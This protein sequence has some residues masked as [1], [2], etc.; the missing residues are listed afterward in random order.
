MVYYTE[1]ADAWLRSGN[2]EKALVVYK[3]AARLDSTSNQPFIGM[4]N[5]YWL[6]GDT[7]KA[8]ENWEKAFRINPTNLEICK[9]LLGYYTS[10]GSTKAVYYKAKVRELQKSP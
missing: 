9:N 6:S 8:I 3:K 2:R 7:V 1:E 5:I 4:G 10:K